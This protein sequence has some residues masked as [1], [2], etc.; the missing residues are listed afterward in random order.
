[1]VLWCYTLQQITYLTKGFAMAYFLK[2]TKNKKG[3]YLQI[4]ESHWDAIRGHTV[5]KSVRA[6]GYEHE[7]KAAG[8]TDPIAHYKAQVKAMNDQRKE[9]MSSRKQ[10]RISDT[11]PEVYLGHFPMSA[12]NKRL[13]VEKDFKYLSLAS[14]FRFNLFELLSD[15]VY[16]R[17][18]CSCSKYKTYTEVLPHLAGAHKTYSVDQLY[19]GLAFLGQEYKKIIEM[20]NVKINEV[21]GRDTS[22]TYFDCTNFF[23]E[24]DSEDELRKKGPSKERSVSPIVGMGLLLDKDCIPLGMSIY[25]GNESEKPIMRDVVDALKKRNSI[26]GRTIH[27]AD[28][29]LNCADNIASSV[30]SG[31]GYIFSKSVKQL[32]EQEQAWALTDEGWTEIKHADGSIAYCYK[33]CVDEFEY[34]V[35]SR[36]NKKKKV[37]LKEKRMVTYNPQLAKKQKAEIA[38]Q[39]EK[40]QEKRLAGA[41]KSEFGDS[42]KFVKFVSVDSNGEASSKRIVTTLDHDAIKRAYRLAGYNM[43]VTSEIDLSC[44]EIYAT[45][46]ELWHIE[47]TFKTMKSQLNARPVFLQKPDSIVGHFL[48]CY[49]AV[50]LERLVQLKVLNKSACTNKVMKFARSFKAVEV[51][52]RNYINTS[53]S[54]DVLKSLQEI[55][56]LPLDNYYLTKGQINDITNFTF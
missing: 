22:K 25:P 42:A 7:L 46:H 35:T 8:I 27:V 45:Y 24:I 40:A 20:Y 4:Y 44:S 33:S 41:K 18:V 15:L 37:K 38:R 5:N 2:K 53:Q 26:K 55:T 49:V 3:L 54:S 52:E 43:I 9:D 32:P 16:A 56:Q 51:S 1:M 14:G 13:G 17:L 31:D 19:D 6:I 48:V 29:G 39:V 36:E 34:K 30:L 23:F 47:E 10:K 11:S 28:K 12:L 21:F 50:L